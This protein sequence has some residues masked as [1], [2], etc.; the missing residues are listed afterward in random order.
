MKRKRR[1]ILLLVVFCVLL[2]PVAL[3]A[4]YAWM[5][6]DEPVSDANVAI[7]IVPSPECYDEAAQLLTSG[8]VEQIILVDQNPRRSVAMGANPSL[9]EMA[10]I[11]LSTRKIPKDAFQVVPTTAMTPHEMFRQLDAHVTGEMQ[12]MVI[13]SST[14][15]KYYRKVIDQ[16]LPAQQ[17]KSYR[18]RSILP[19]A[20]D[21][22]SWWKTRSGVRR[23]MNH[24]LRLMF[25]L[26]HGE[27]DVDPT[28]PYKHLV[29]QA[30]NA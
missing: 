10:S 5:I 8:K 26:C 11:E 3:Q 19:K 15:S 6:T 29:E 21:A 4:A 20:N 23:V 1:W 14:L 12:C 2:H 22:S 9:A 28:D 24:G 27:S 17:A 25:V 13:S 18:L 16:A 30:T 7:V